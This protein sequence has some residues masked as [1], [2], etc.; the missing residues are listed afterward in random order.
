MNPAS[1]NLYKENM[2]GIKKVIKFMELFL[3]NDMLEK[4]LWQE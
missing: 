4:V 1:I 3:A 2:A